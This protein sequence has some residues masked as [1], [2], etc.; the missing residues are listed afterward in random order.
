MEEMQH[1]RFTE[2]WKRGN[3]LGG[4]LDEAEKV[5][6]LELEPGND[7]PT[8]KDQIEENQV[9]MYFSFKRQ[10]LGRISGYGIS[11]SQKEFNKKNKKRARVLCSVME[12]LVS[13]K[14]T[15]ELLR[16]NQPHTSFSRVHFLSELKIHKW[17]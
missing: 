17:F 12:P 4:W 1:K 16:K 8:L 13:F 6:E 15:K 2:W 10:E 11:V 14:F 9:N 7:I 3:N 5:L